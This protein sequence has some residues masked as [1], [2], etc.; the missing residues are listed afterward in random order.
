ML[1]LVATE[2][3]T[4]TEIVDLIH[5]FG[6]RIIMHPREPYGPSSVEFF[7]AHAMHYIMKDGVCTGAQPVIGEDGQYSKAFTSPESGADFL[8]LKCT[9]AGR[10]LVGKSG[11]DLSATPAVRGCVCA[12][13]RVRVRTTLILRAVRVNFTLA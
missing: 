1:P 7:L 4:R 12:C 10:D 9:F 5:K 13:V 2:P 6:P 3:F 11:A 8:A